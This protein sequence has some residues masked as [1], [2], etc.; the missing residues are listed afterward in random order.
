MTK[1]KK[2]QMKNITTTIILGIFLISLASALTID[3]GA[4]EILE[5][6]TGNQI[7]WTASGNSSSLDGINITQEG[8]NITICL[9]VM[10]QEDSFSIL[11][12]EEQTKEVIVE[13][14]VGG[15]GGGSRTKYVEKNNTIY[16]DRNIVKY[17]DIEPINFIPNKIVKKIPKGI[18]YF[19]GF[20]SLIIIGLF[21]RLYFLKRKIKLSN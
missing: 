19:V 9:D 13:V 1:Q 2:N 5:I 21:I 4:C 18:F 17:K 12:I 8:K 16:R 10:F 15:G 7:F 6:E 11:L 14:Q 3:A 20:L